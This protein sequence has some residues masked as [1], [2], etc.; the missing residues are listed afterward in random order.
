MSRSIIKNKNVLS[1][2]ASIV[3]FFILSTA[4]QAQSNSNN[5]TIDKK[6]VRVDIG[7]GAMHCPF[8]SPKLEAKLRE[9]K[10]IENFFIDKRNSYATFN[11]PSDTE[12]TS[13][14]L[15]KIGT[16]VGYPADDVVITIDSKPIKVIEKQP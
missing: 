1:I 10:N 7:H 4:S 15:K 9:I 3:F 8:L 16:D 12:M 6:Y 5:P 14:S 2:I 11:L 13:E